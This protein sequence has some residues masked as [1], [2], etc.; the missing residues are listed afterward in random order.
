[1]KELI[2]TKEIELD[3]FIKKYCWSLNIFPQLHHLLKDLANYVY[4][5]FNIVIILVEE[6][7]ATL[8]IRQF[9]QKL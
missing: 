9:S 6:M 8:G 3:C 1:M 2:I 5:V 4:K 7:L